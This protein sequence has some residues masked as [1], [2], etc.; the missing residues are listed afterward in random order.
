MAASSS[1]SSSR[2]QMIRVYSGRVLARFHF[3]TTQFQDLY[4]QRSVDEQEKQR[5][6]WEDELSAYF[7]NDFSLLV[8]DVKEGSLMLDVQL[9]IGCFARVWRELK[10]RKSPCL[11]GSLAKLS[12]QRVRPLTSELD[13]L[14]LAADCIVAPNSRDLWAS[15]LRAPLALPAD[16]QM[17][18]IETNVNATYQHLLH[19]PT[20][21]QLA[22]TSDTDK[23]IQKQSQAPAT[24]TIATS[25]LPMPVIDVNYTVSSEVWYPDF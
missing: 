9:P 18:E 12:L 2:Q 22:Q 19:A 11:P 1:F 14:Q 6:Q 13:I 24:Y 23:Q 17:Q 5:E 15:V 25:A 8:M 16:C 7:D 21:L 4:G 20:L 10:Q 3:E